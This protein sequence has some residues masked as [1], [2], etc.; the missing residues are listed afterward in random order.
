MRACPFIYA[1]VFVVVV[2]FCIDINMVTKD[3]RHLETAKKHT[4][5]M[6]SNNM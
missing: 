4:A 5:D 6:H 2:F 3:V 1:F